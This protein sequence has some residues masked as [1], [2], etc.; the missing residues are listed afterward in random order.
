M[1]T[2]KP[3]SLEN[4]IKTI[5][6]QNFITVDQFLELK[7]YSLLPGGF[8][9]NDQKSNNNQIIIFNALL[10]MQENKDLNFFK[11]YQR[12]PS[13]KIAEIF[14][15]EMDN[16]NAENEIITLN[17]DIHRCIFNQWRINNK[18][19]NYKLDDFKEKTE[20]FLK[21]NKNKYSYYQGY[22]DFCA[23]FYNLYYEKNNKNSLEQGYL[24]T[25][26]LKLFTE[27]YLK[28]YI[29]PF[30]AI[31]RNEDIIFENSIAVLIDIINIID[32][33]IYILL[34][35]ESSP[36]CLCLS[37]VITLFTHEINNFYTIR[38][39]LDYLLLHEPIDVYVLCALIIVKSFQ[40]TIKNVEDAENEDVFLCIK[41]IDLNNI[42]FNYMIVECDKFI[43]NN[44][45]DILYVQ[46][47]NQNLLYLVGDY[48]Y[49]GFENIVYSY[50][51]KQL[52][53]RNFEENKSFIV[54]YKFIFILF[55]IWIFV[56]YFFKKDK[57]LN[58]LNRNE[59]IENRDK[60][61]IKNST[62]INE[63]DE[64]I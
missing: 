38:R 60:N 16:K 5:K 4:L 15:D 11:Q 43:N 18:E 19:I 56:I 64:D 61:L 29:S 1:T 31:G 52:P 21:D 62:R 23:F 51:K 34:K 54:S 24:F 26:A 36:L 49:R 47:K 28:D 37:W 25:D 48:N 40:K 27:L 45:N 32:P 6:K 13:K 35:E 44:F 12:H 10:N 30:K 41:N 9:A 8:S 17:K 53:D 22:L 50:N 2:E 59:S 57:I 42:D 58:E 55:L 20:N 33:K 14:K 63:E 7:D 39:I 46:E 3:N